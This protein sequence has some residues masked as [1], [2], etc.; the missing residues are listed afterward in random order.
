M[1]IKSKDIIALLTLIICFVLLLLHYNGFVQGVMILVL[2]YYFVK[3]QEGK[4]NG[5]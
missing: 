3:R 5:S 2:S 4:D 1:K